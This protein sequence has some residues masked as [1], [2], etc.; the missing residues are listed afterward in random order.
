MSDLEVMLQ[1]IESVPP[2]PAATAP[3]AGTFYS[4]QHAPGTRQAWPPLPGNSRQLPV[5]NLGDDIYLL[6][7]RQVDDSLPL[8]P[9]RTAGMM[10]A[11]A[12]DGMAP[13]G[14]GDGTNDFY[15]NS[16]APLVFT[17]NELWLEII[18][19][20]NFATNLTAHLVI[21]TPWNV[22]NG[23]YGLYFNT[24]LVF[25]YDWT[26]LQANA[27]GQTNLVVTNLPPPVGF[28]MLG[29]PTAI[30]PGFTNNVLT[31]ND[32]DACC[33]VNGYDPDEGDTLLT[34]LLANIGFPINFFGQLTRIFL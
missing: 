7:D 18:G 12:F 6:D 2:A 8:N 17:T 27:P 5:W 32:D 13:P 34:N 14:G 31:A 21:H 19:T 16:L 23:V 4:A 3:R 24:N 22:T 29:D 15:S 25:S 28:F 10:A 30:R 1:A 33:Y 9:A 20:T 26:W 11:T